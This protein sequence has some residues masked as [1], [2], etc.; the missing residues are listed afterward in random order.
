MKITL[1][2]GDDEQQLAMR[3]IH[4]SEAFTR[5]WDISHTLRNFLKHGDARF[6]TAQDLAM[7]LH[8]EVCEA[9]EQVPE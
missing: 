4:G 8:N 2:F 1:E 5:L 3:S 6:K 7:Y 9:L